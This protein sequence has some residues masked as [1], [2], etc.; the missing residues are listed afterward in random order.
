MDLSIVV[1]SWNTRD[2]LAQCL[3]SIFANP[4]R[5]SFDVW[6]VD[7]ASQD[8]S[9]QF[10]DE[11]FPQVHLI[12]NLQNLGFAR[13][14]NQGIRASSGRA[15]LLL[16]SDTIVQPQALDQMLAFIEAHPEAGVVGAGLVN[17]DGTPQWC[18]G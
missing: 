13:A 14:N 7:N 9:A 4:P 16:N 8:G 1:V 10:I 2:L 12:R 17:A 15:V 5:A 3:A 11:Q 6:V 18:Y